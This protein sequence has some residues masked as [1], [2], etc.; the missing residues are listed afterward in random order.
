MNVKCFWHTLVNSKFGIFYKFDLYAEI[1]NPCKDILQ[2]KKRK[3]LHKL[4][5][6]KVN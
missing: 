2:R 3:I 5:K 6:G 4:Q 1:K